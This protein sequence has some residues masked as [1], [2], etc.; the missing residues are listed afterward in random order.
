MSA[1][2]SKKIPIAVS[3]SVV[4]YSAPPTWTQACTHTF[5]LVWSDG[6]SLASALHPPRQTCMSRRPPSNNDGREMVASGRWGEL[7]APG[8]AKSDPT[9]PPRHQPSTLSQLLCLSRFLWRTALWGKQSS[10]PIILNQVMNSDRA[11]P[12]APTCAS[13]YRAR[14]KQKIWRNRSKIC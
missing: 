13:G 3:W 9:H 8:K 4:L 1:K 10:T 5:T 2:Q 11:R 14:E 12:P 7:A 6:M